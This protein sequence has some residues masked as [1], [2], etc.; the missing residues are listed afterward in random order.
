[1]VIGA[2]IAGSAGPAVSLLQIG[3][4]V[5]S[6]IAMVGTTVAVAVAVDHR[7]VRIHVVCSLVGGVL[8][9]WM[10]WGI[11]VSDPGYAII[12]CF[13]GWWFGYL[14]PAMIGCVVGFTCGFVT[15]LAWFDPHIPES[16]YLAALLLVVETAAGVSL[17]LHFDR[18]TRR[19]RLSVAGNCE[20]EVEAW[21]PVRPKRVSS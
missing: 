2:A 14:P 11:G 9:F 13:I 1:M 3:A 8:A 4:T 19:W 20:D 12:G 15:G 16:E 7:L 17:A 5:A 10:G 21:R 18:T 6:V